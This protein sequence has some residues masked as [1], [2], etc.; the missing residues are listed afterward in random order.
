MTRGVDQ[1]EVVVMAV[2]RPICQSDRLCLDRYAPLPLQIHRV[3]DLLSHVTLADGA[4]Q[5]EEAIGQG[6]LPMVDMGDDREVAYARLI[7]HG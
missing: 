5:L 4:G 7:G 3:E 2:G 1:I 6:R